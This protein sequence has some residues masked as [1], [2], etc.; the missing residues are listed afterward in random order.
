VVE[1]VVEMLEVVAVVEAWFYT[2]E[3]MFVVIQVTLLLLVV[4]EQ[5]QEEVIKVAQVVIQQVFL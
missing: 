1:Q 3:Q 5:L 2:L 4:A